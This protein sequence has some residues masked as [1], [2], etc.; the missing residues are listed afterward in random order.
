MSS[1]VSLLIA[2]VHSKECKES[3]PLSTDGF[4][5][6]RDLLLDPSISLQRGGQGNSPHGDLPA[7]AYETMLEYFN[8]VDDNGL[9]V[10]NS[11]A[12]D[13]L[14]ESLFGERGSITL[15][16]TFINE[17]MNFDNAAGIESIDISLGNVTIDNINTVV[18]PFILLDPIDAYTLNNSLSL[19]SAD[20]PLEVGV[21]LS[22]MVDSDYLS[23]DD[24]IEFKL[25]FENVTVLA[26]IMA[27]MRA[28]SFA[29]FPLD[30]V[31]DLGCWLSLIPLPGELEDVGS[32]LSLDH[33]EVSFADLSFGV[34]CVECTSAGMQELPVILD[35]LD[36]TL[37]LNLNSLASAI[38]G[39]I[40]SDITQPLLDSYHSEL[41]WSCPFYDDY[42]ETSGS[43]VLS[44]IESGVLDE[45]ELITA[46]TYEY[47]AVLT[48]ALLESLVVVFSM[49]LES[50][51]YVGNDPLSAQNNAVVPEDVDLLDFNE[52]LA[53]IMIDELKGLISNVED[54]NSL[55][56]DI[57]LDDGM[58]SLSPGIEYELGGSKL[59]M[60]S[61]VVEG[62]DSLVEFDIL[63]V[64]APQ[65]FTNDVVFE[66]ISLSLNITIDVGIDSQSRSL[67]RIVEDFTIS[68]T[69]SNVSSSLSLY[70]PI[71]L[72]SLG[73]M[74]LGS[75]LFS[76]NLLQCALSTLY[77]G[78]NVTEFTFS[79]DD[80]SALEFTGISSEYINDE[81]F[82]MTSLISE[83]YGDVIEG[84]IPA[85]IEIGGLVVI[86]EILQDFSD[87][88]CPPAFVADMIV[89]FRDL[90]LY[91]SDATNAGATGLSPYGDLWP[92]IISFVENN[93]LLIKGLYYL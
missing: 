4:V 55:I 19:E 78:L 26:E 76:S 28:E 74:E 80:I 57:V 92:E 1:Y 79:F 46:D 72:S 51:E 70:V 21:G 87:V 64:L 23:M 10:V 14:T 41:V 35:L 69:L 50:Y 60:N 82:S 32:S 39:E 48:V 89:D 71:D 88:S 15:A 84:A 91:P 38:L 73:E 86:N 75:L 8:G 24:R 31:F 52:G 53:S 36:D 29:D 65:T 5:D 68:T 37:S 9:L 20:S 47:F 49:N 16:D 62:L 44:T 13:P 42:D 40:D 2:E 61:V 27:M 17:S 85:L 22:L 59:S 63:N 34:S 83:V 11:A 54:I 77:T 25:G 6:F 67:E 45:M 12:I 56:G 93:L 7:L 30:N 18:A 66:Q 90:L 43:N 58:L 81:I 3:I 33:L